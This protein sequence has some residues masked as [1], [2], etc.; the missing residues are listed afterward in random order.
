MCIGTSNPELWTRVVHTIWRRCITC[1]Y[2]H[3]RAC[4][5]HPPSCLPSFYILTIGIVLKEKPL[6]RGQL[7]SETTNF[8]HWTLSLLSLLPFPQRELHSTSEIRN[9]VETTGRDI[10]SVCTCPSSA[11]LSEQC[12]GL[13]LRLLAAALVLVLHCT[14][15][16]TCHSCAVWTVCCTCTWLYLYLYLPQLSWTVCWFETEIGGSSTIPQIS[17]FRLFPLYCV[18]LYCCVG[19]GAG[20]LCR[21]ISSFCLLPPPPPFAQGHCFFLLSSSPS[22]H[23]TLWTKVFSL[24]FSKCST[25]CFAHSKSLFSH[26]PVQYTSIY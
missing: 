7:D 19:A 26:Y 21:S 2:L 12:A 5:I 15:A 9:W 1:T 3:C 22:S 4:T 8:A 24:Q 6:G 10:W 17:T 13:R 16:F 14:C 23:I 25:R 20:V 18:P 11:V